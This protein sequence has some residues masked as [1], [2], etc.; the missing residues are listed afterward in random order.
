[1]YVS[2]YVKKNEDDDD[3]EEDDDDDDADAD[4]DMKKK[5]MMMM[6]MMTNIHKFVVFR[7]FFRHTRICDV[8]SP[9]M[10]VCLV[11][12]QIIEIT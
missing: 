5:M 4:A 11:S 3:D 6:R 7:Y 9:V 2:H 1:M 12:P 8:C 10:F